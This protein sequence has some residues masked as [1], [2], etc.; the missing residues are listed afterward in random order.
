[1]AALRVR[2]GDFKLNTNEDG[3]YVEKN[4]TTV[5]RHTDFQPQGKNPAVRDGLNSV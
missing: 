4:V 5:Y 2:L 3:Q 1:M